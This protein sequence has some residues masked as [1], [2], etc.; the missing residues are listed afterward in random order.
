MCAESRVI[1]RNIGA[2]NLGTRQLGRKQPDA[3]HIGD[4]SESNRNKKCTTA[5][6]WPQIG[7][8]LRYINTSPR[9]DG[10]S[11]VKLLIQSPDADNAETEVSRALSFFL[12]CRARDSRLIQ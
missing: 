3:L 12:S 2:M 8:R 11:F 6:R 7:T 4:D 1:I 5:S 9:P 10:V